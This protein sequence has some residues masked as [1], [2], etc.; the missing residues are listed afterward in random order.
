ME[1]IALC[2]CQKPFSIGHENIDGY[3]TACPGDAFTLTQSGHLPC[4]DDLI[5]HALCFKQ[6]SSPV[7]LTYR[8]GHSLVLRRSG[9]GAGSISDRNAISTRLFR[10]AHLPYWS[11]GLFEGRQDARKLQLIIKPP[12]Q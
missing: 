4:I 7:L 1:K 5:S 8:F 6:V 2:K 12:H 10:N 11:I 3:D 9:F